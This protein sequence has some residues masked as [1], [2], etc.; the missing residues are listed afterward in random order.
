MSQQQAQADFVLDLDQ[1]WH[2]TTTAADGA[3]ISRL[4]IGHYT[5]EITGVEPK[6]KEGKKP[7]TMLLTTFRVVKGPTEEV[8]GQTI[9]GL[10]A[11]SKQSP[12]FM[13]QRLKCL[14]DA[15]KVVPKGGFKPQK[16]L[17]GKTFDGTVVWELS[18]PTADAE[19]N[20]KRYVNARVRYERQAGQAVPPHATH[21]ET[22]SKRAISYLQ[23]NGEGGDDDTVFTP[24]GGDE[25]PPW[26]GAGEG[27][28]AG[29]GD[30]GAGAEETTTGG[31]SWKDDSEI[32]PSLLPTVMTFRAYIYLGT[33][34][35]AE[36]RQNLESEAINPEGTIDE[37]LIE[38]AELVAKVVAKRNPPAAKPAGLRPLGGGLPGLGGAKVGTRAPAVAK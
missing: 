8:V 3:P 4:P 24:G 15:V 37:S 23:Q 30:D 29:G 6:P 7:H 28:A 13:Q 38:D 35:A 27:D 36:A 21:Y 9:D 18:N 26:M 10:Y 11:G 19:G 12:K 16:E 31:P 1:N 17:V 25:A 22:E 14:L 33:D 20:A 34:E 5:F 32:D 2:S